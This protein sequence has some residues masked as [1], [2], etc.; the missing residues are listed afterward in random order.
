MSIRIFLRRFWVIRIVLSLALFGCGGGGG[1]EGVGNSDSRNTPVTPTVVSG[2]VDVNGGLI[3]VTD[4]AS[5]IFGTKVDVPVNAV[6]QNESII[7][8][9]SY[10]DNLPK[11]LNAANAKQVSK[12]I[13]LSKSDSKNFLK[14]VAVTI[15]YADNELNAGDVPAVFYFDTFYDAYVSAGVEEIDTAAEFITFKT[16]HFSQFVAI[17]IAGLASAP[18]GTD[19]GFLPGQDGFFHPNFGAYEHPGGSSLGMA[20]Y[21]QWYYS[22]KRP[23]DGEDLYYKYREKV[24]DAWQDDVTARELISRSYYCARQRWAQIYLLSD[25]LIGENHT[26]LLLLTTLT[27]SQIPQTLCFTGEERDPDTNQVTAQWGHAVTVYKFE[28]GKF[29]I[30]DSNF[31]GEVVAIDWDPVH[32]FSGYSKEAAYIGSNGKITKWGFEAMGNIFEYKEFENMYAGAENRWTGPQFVTITVTT[33]ALDT[34]SLAVIGSSD[35]LEVSGTVSGGTVPATHIFYSLNGAGDRED[36]DHVDTNTGEYRFIIPNLPNPTNTVHLMATADIKDFFRNIPDSYASF[37]EIT[38]I[39]QGLDFFENNGFETGDDTGWSHETHTWQDPTPGS[40]SPE[41]SEIVSSGADELIPLI[42]KVYHGNYSFRVND[43]LG[44]YHISSVS[45]SRIVPTMTNPTLEFYWAAVLQDP[46]HPPEVQ[47]Y[48]ELEVV[49]ETSGNTLYYKHFYSN[50]PSYSG[51]ID[52]GHVGW[53]GIPWQKV[54]VNLGNSIGDT[55]RL[56]VL[57]ADCGLGGHGGYVY[58]DGLDLN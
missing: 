8:T 56:K 12:V 54:I 27:V 5:P 16:V 1:G 7:I 58:I 23:E 45:Q 42:Q 25:Y 9:I 14:P 2:T 40:F 33:P 38:L 31:P 17:G 57:A 34:N 49:N 4:P 28:S 52:S 50:D 47:P 43:F 41:D 36:F 21:A 44:R 26:G 37:K 13:I 46:Q 15:P 51:W 24:Y 18:V 3:E 19:T 6:D 32:G 55:V 10:Q 30:Y 39:I 29:Y 22:F 53:K 48:I 35:N 11:P 20:N